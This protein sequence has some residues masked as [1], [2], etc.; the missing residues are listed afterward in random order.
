LRIRTKWHNKGR[1]KSIEELAGVVAFNAWKMAHTTVNRMFSEGF[2]FQSKQQLLET[3][4]EF[5]A[6]LIQAAD[7]MA[8]RRL[9]EEAR[10]RFVRPLA[11]QLIATL[12]DNQV[13]E[14][15]AGEYRPAAVAIINERLE[16]YADF[17]YVDDEPSFPLLRYFGTC[18]DG[19][20][21]GNNK[22]VIEQ[23]AEVEAPAL[24]K[25]LRRTIDDL[26]AQQSPPEE[27][28]T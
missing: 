11:S 21:G 9:D 4:R 1:E 25:Q 3:V 23:V 26:L 2:N 5:V 13:E 15:G 14:L 28:A 16:A 19:V 24:L 7:R 18:V 12:V 20:L 10:Q 8:H 17:A 22:W 6:F 27:G